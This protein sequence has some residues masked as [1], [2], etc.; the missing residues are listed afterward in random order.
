[1]KQSENVVDWTCPFVS[2]D[3]FTVYTG[4][5][6]ILSDLFQLCHSSV[7]EAWC[8]QRISFNFVANFA[9]QSLE[10]GRH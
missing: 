9:L 5:L 8:L 7:S 10:Y 1:M 2:K 4:K 3:H 6:P